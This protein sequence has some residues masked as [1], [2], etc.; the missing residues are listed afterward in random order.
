MFKNNHQIIDFSRVFLWSRGS[1]HALIYREQGSSS[2]EEGSGFLQSW[3]SWEKAE[4]RDYA[5]MLG[6]MG[7]S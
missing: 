6:V 3:N 4:A 7:Q 2:S 1:G 5:G